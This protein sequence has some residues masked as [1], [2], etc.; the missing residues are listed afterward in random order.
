MSART[1]PKV[2]VI[3]AKSIASVEFAEAEMAAVSFR[4]DEKRNLS[5]T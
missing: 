4:T 3:G 2:T 5:R 1:L